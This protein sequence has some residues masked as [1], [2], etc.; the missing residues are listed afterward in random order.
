[1]LPA[2]DVSRRRYSSIHNVRCCPRGRLP[3]ELDRIRISLEVF[4]LHRDRWLGF[5]MPG[6]YFFAAVL[7]W[8]RGW[9]RIVFESC[10][11]N[12]PVPDSAQQTFSLLAGA[13]I[14]TPG[15]MKMRRRARV[16]SEV[17]KKSARSISRKRVCP[18]GQLDSSLSIL[19]RCA[20]IIGID[21]AR[22]IGTRRL[23][24]RATL[25]GSQ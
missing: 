14:L 25:R 19:P 11:R 8:A 16:W 3:A 5:A 9:K 1:M 4:S 10:E 21:P 2:E 12:E 15:D 6:H 17:V 7:A 18:A 23:P 24:E 22:S 13:G 20:G